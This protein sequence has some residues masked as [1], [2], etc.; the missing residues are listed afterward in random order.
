MSYKVINKELFSLY[1]QK[2]LADKVGIK[3]ETLNR[4]INGKQT[5]SKTTAYC[6]VKSIDC[7]ADILTFFVKVGEK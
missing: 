6:I 4:I 5:T 7:N 1:N 2:K 3:T